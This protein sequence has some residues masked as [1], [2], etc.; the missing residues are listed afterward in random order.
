M[1]K[2]FFVADC[3]PSK[4]YYFQTLYE[5]VVWQDGDDEDDS[6]T[7]TEESSDNKVGVNLSLHN[8]KFSLVLFIS[9]R[10]HFIVIRYN[11][12]TGFSD[13]SFH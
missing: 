5:L 4:N 10:N 13:L 11:S 1:F 3:Y 8:R 7:D 2:I 9:S 12:S 6:D